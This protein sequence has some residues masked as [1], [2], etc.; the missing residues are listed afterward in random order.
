MKRVIFLLSLILT[1]TYSN[2]QTNIDSLLSDVEKYQ[3]EIFNSRTFTLTNTKTYD[4]AKAFKVFENQGMYNSTYLILNDDS[5]YIYYSVYEVGFDLTTGKWTRFNSDTFTLNWDE[6]KT[7][8]YVND[9][10][11]YKKFFQYGSP[12]FAPMISWLIKISGDK[13][14]PVVIANDKNCNQ[15]W[16]L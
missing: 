1:S 10:K 7:L 15:Q 13:I 4:I 6:A 16:H 9:E 5:T 14:E 3:H 11:I 2:S 12:T 8:N